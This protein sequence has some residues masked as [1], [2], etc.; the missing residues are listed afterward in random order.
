MKFLTTTVITLAIVAF[1]SPANLSARTSNHNEGLTSYTEGFAGY[2]EGSAKGMFHPSAETDPAEK[3]LQEV[4]KNNTTLSALRKEALARK[5]GNRTDIYPSNPEVEFGYLWGSPSS[6]GTR[7]DFG[8]SQT[9]DFPLAYSYKKKIADLRDNQIDLEYQKSLRDIRYE[10]SMV[11][12]DL[13]YTNALT[14]EIEKQYSNAKAIADAFKKRF[15]AGDV[16]RL[17]LNKAEINLYHVT[18]VLEH[19]NI[20]REY[21]LNQLSGLNGGVRIDFESSTFGS[22]LIP[23]SFENWYAEA[24]KESPVLGWLRQNIEISQKEISLT[25]ALALPQITTGYMSEK[26]VGEKFQGVTFG[27]TVPL[28]ENKNK[29]KQAKAAAEAAE[30]LAADEKVRFYTSLKALHSKTIGLQNSVNDFQEKILTFNNVEMLR[31]ALD[32]GELSI[33]DYFHEVEFYYESIEHM[34][35]LEREFNKTAA[36]LRL[37]IM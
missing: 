8:V 22:Q 13:I 10:T 27:I 1:A 16:S 17:E 19:L 37:Q 23:S 28:W 7:Q 29:I 6:M 4:E 32:L 31:K 36:Q 2:T 30:S 33:I 5:L 9:L 18:K 3:I 15:D 11:I 24:E 34:L 35:D 25:K 21:L 26:V 14:I 20:D 12:Y